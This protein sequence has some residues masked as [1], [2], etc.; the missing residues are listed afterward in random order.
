[1]PK[2]KL[3]PF[4]LL[5][6]FT[7]VIYG[8][9]A[10]QVVKDIMHG[11]APKEV[12]P[13]D[14]TEEM[15]FD[16]VEDVLGP[17]F[18]EDGPESAATTVDAGSSANTVGPEYDGHFYYFGSGAGAEAP[19]RPRGRPRSHRV[20]SEYADWFRVQAERARGERGDSA[21]TEPQE[22]AMSRE[23]ACRV[24]GVPLGAPA[25]V[26]RQAFRVL[27]KRWHPDVCPEGPEKGGIMFTKIAIA[28]K[29]LVPK[30][31]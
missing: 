12:P 15:I 11:K 19:R 13:E 25:P 23:E 21:P 28:Y 8:K 7:K 18:F 10:Y 6:G 16:A 3:S 27:A 24:L 31:I 4:D 1:V 17:G 9:S 26:I 14:I 5:N 22:F 30:P 2:K 20:I 29:V